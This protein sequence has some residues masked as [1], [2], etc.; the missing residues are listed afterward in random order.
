MTPGDAAAAL[1]LLPIADGRRLCELAVFAEQGRIE[2]TLVPAFWEASSGLGLLEG[3]RLC[4]ELVDLSILAEDGPAVRLEPVVRAFLREQLTVPTLAAAHAAVLRVALGRLS[5]GRDQTAWWDLPRDNRYLWTHLPGHLRESG[6]L[7]ELAKCVGDLRWV[8]TKISL[9]GTAAAEADVALVDAAWARALR[10]ELARAAH[11]L[12]MARQ[13]D[14]D[15]TATPLFA[16]MRAADT[17]DCVSSELVNRLRNVAEL[18]S[19]LAA[20]VEQLPPLPRLFARPE[21][22]QPTPTSRRTLL[23]S[24]PGDHCLVAPDASWLGVAGQRVR[25]WDSSTGRVVADAAAGAI[26]RPVIAPDGSWLAVPGRDT[27]RVLDP[28]TGQIIR[29]HPITGGG[30]AGLAV[31]GDGSWLACSRFPD[32]T[33]WIWDTMTGRLRAEVSGA[34]LA[35]AACGR[36]LVTG[37][38]GKVTIRD[39]EDGSPVHILGHMRAFTTLAAG[40]APNGS[41]LAIVGEHGDTIQVWDIATGRLRF[42]IPY[43]DGA[44]R[45]PFA[46]APH[47]SSWL[48]VVQ[49]HT[50]RVWDTGVGTNVAVLEAHTL[51]IRAL[52]VSP[53]GSWL[54]T[55]GRDGTVRVWEAA[56]WQTRH[57]F[58]DLGGDLFPAPDGSWLAVGDHDA[59]QVWDT[60]TGHIRTRIPKD[61]AC[62]AAPDGSWTATLNRSDHALRIWDIPTGPGHAV[63]VEPSPP[64]VLRA[65]DAGDAPFG[66]GTRRIMV[67]DHG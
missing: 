5:A 21:H 53:D 22:L 7:T 2:R 25:L 17:R 42:T 37:Q 38:P 40:V 41:W 34:G 56:T 9:C 32:S 48:A 14:A 1:E 49:D 15:P 39:P 8:A 59:T 64:P 51:P 26:E 19:R 33:A 6:R 66:H 61:G 31:A 24:D 23:V 57:L 12:D 35:L 4:A 65:H 3:E 27:V 62:A 52:V 54:A 28:R 67:G 29:T 60:A 16:G 55:A 50:V 13:W 46:I 20:F 58:P 44:E 45:V 30:L 11:V 18:D 63:P 47:D 10:R 36:W 43:A